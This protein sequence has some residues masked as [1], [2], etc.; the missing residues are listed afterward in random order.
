MTDHALGRPIS[1]L[2]FGTYRWAATA[3]HTAALYR[4]LD[5]GCTLI[6]TA[7]NYATAD[8]R[9]RLGRVLASRR[10]EL[11]V[12]SKGGY[13]ADGGYCLDPDFIRR[14]IQTEAELVGGG[15]L[16]TFLLHNPEH[17]LA[18]C[19]TSQVMEAI[20][21]A[22]A[23]CVEQVA[24][25]TIRS[26]GISSNV[27][28]TP[29]H[30]MGQ[31]AVNTYAR[32]GSELNA[33]HAL[34]YLQFPHNIVECS[35][36]SHQWLD[37]CRAL[38]FTTI[39]NRPLSPLTAGGPVRIADPPRDRLRPPAEILAD[40]SRQQHGLRPIL[41]HWGQVASP[42]AL[43]YVGSL[44]ERA[45]QDPDNVAVA[46]IVRELISAK[47]VELRHTA[48]LRTFE[49]LESPELH[50]DLSGNPDDSVA[51]RACQTYL[52]ELDHVLVGFRRIAD[53]NQLAS[54]FHSRLWPPKETLRAIS[55]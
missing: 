19:G 18:T 45:L 30:A 39:G 21:D 46:P 52:R 40:L 20:G 22:F 3:D 32:L 27:V 5:L 1:P 6:D 42:D 37:R 50:I 26:F 4:A 48:S 10:T 33:G 9:A 55:P 2:G 24:A 17:L 7:P 51:V 31:D 29:S 43:D 38:G 44:V 12:I 36:L 34:R 23:V 13:T 11:H 28:A 54:L 47:R 53:V 16:D 25:G 35:A 49:L 41:Q 15:Y 14:R 8:V